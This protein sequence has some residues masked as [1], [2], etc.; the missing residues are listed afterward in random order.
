[1][2]K[3]GL[4]GFEGGFIF[5]L[6]K[7]IRSKKLSLIYFKLKNMKLVPKCNLSIIALFESLLFKN[8]RY[9]YKQLNIMNV[10]KSV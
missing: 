4:D 6:K 5:F 3:F 2:G 8:N 10:R 9:N 1:M 7:L